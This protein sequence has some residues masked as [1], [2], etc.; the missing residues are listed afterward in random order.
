MSKTQFVLTLEDMPNVIN[1]INSLDTLAMFRLILESGARFNSMGVLS[2]KD[3]D[4]SQQ[5]LFIRE[6]MAKRI[7]TVFLTKGTLDFLQK[8][9][10][11]FKIKSNELCFRRK[12]SAYNSELKDAGKKAKLGFP[13]TTH[14]LRRSFIS[15][16]SSCG[17]NLEAIL[18][19]IGTSSHSIEECFLAINLAKKRRELLVESYGNLIRKLDSIY[20]KRYDELK[21]L[22]VV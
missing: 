16:A 3:I 7:H 14:N 9:V 8:Y 21:Q 15:Q 12:L 18:D 5:I 17:V 22:G 11:D 13:L 10:S 20:C 6:P 1:A 2:P 4:C 19:Q